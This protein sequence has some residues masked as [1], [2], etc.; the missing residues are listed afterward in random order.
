[1]KVKRRLLG[2]CIVP[3]NYVKDK[4]KNKG[5][6]T[7]NNS[8]F[9][10]ELFFL[11]EKKD[12]M[13]SSRIMRI[14]EQYMKE[15]DMNNTNI[16]VKYF[17]SLKVMELSSEIATNMNIFTEEEITVCELIG[18]FHDLGSFSKN[19][20]FHILNDNEDNTSKTLEI[21]F[22][23]GLIRK[24]TKETK[25]DAIIKFAIFSLNKN[26]YPNNLDSK[27]I[28]FCEVLKDAD[29]I[30]TFR[31]T[32]NYPYIDTRINSYP[33]ALAYNEFKLFR[34]VESKLTE[35]NADEVLLVLSNIFSFYSKYSLYIVKQ[36]NYVDKLIDALSFDD[37]NVKKFFMSLKQVLNIY[38]ER[39]IGDINVRQE[40]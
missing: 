21:L 11:K 1:M 26:G 9:M 33:S 22:T 15:F 3:C 8:S 20:N 36:N 32:I 16:K 19:P 34:K 27:I 7:I 18:L 37:E 4:R 28:S 23:N 25:Y 13:K 31:L 2:S 6:T 39:K 14:F 10:D 24:I 29:K 17:H 5:G 40:V 35:N 30:D 12:N 38:I